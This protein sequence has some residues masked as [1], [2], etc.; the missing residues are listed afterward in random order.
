MS[1]R[2]NVL[3]QEFYLAHEEPVFHWGSEQASNDSLKRDFSL[4]LASLREI[5]AWKNVDGRL[6]LDAATLPIARM[7]GM[8]MDGLNRISVFI[9]RRY[10][11]D[12]YDS[13]RRLYRELIRQARDPHDFVYGLRAIFDP[14]FGKLFV[15]DYR[16]PTETLF[17]ILAIFL[18]Q[19][20]CW[21]DVLWWYPTRHAT[22]KHLLSWLP[23]FTKCIVPHEYDVQPLDQIGTAKSEPKLIVINHRLH[24]EGYVLDK[25][26]DHNHVDKSDQGL[27]LQQLWQFDH[28]LC[29]NHECHDYFAREIAPEDSWL[30][31]LHEMYKDYEE[32]Y[33]YFTSAFRGELLRSTIKVDDARN[34][35]RQVAECDPYWDVLQWYALGV[36][37][38]G[39]VEALAL[40]DGDGALP[41]LHGIFSPRMDTTFREAFADF[42]IGACIYDWGHLS[43][44]L[45]R[46]PDATPWSSSNS[47]YWSTILDSLTGDKKKRSK[48]IKDGYHVF[49]ME[50]Q[51][52]VMQASW[53]Y[54]FYYTYL[55]YIILLDCD[56]H[57]S[58]T[59]MI[60]KLQGAAN[61]IRS[62]YFNETGE[63]VFEV[64]SVRMRIRYLLTVTGLFRGRQLVWTD[65]GFRGITC[66]GME[67]C[68]KKNSV[69]VIVD[70]MSFPV[71]V[72]DFDEKSG[73]G[74]IIGCAL[75]RGVD[76]LNQ[77]SDRAVLPADYKRGKKRTFN[78]K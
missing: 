19:F 11:T 54:S 32:S 39:L 51:P 45:R 78:F 53:C 56:E 48:V 1:S 24:A 13:P 37:T 40:G 70:G 33:V 18:I 67:A 66:P 14:V 46:F 36:R 64:P 9:T 71:V 58:L 50:I 73:E 10:R 7:F 41:Y 69:V 3:Q 74:T 17:A 63:L 2:P 31:V 52:E 76:T 15:P 27:I 57:V 68:C 42:F 5:S 47:R 21:G 29:N 38:E 35:P 65:G 55:A 20:E 75:F 77:D 59:S 12:G 26:Y 62:A 16:M 4:L 22:G 30:E 28:S 49:E 6:M 25:I 60:S 61:K 72:G 34:L 23:D 8:S 44:W 43:I